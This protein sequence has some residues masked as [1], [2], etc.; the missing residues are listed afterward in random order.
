MRFDSIKKFLPRTVLLLTN[1]LLWSLG[2]T[3]ILQS[4][5]IRG[6]DVVAAFNIANTI[7]NVF[8]TIGTA[9]GIA[10]GI[11]IGNLLGANKIEEAKKASFVI[12]A[13]SVVVAL[14]FVGIMIL[15]SFFVPNVYKVSDAIKELSRDLIIVAA[16]SLPF[17]AFNC[18]CYFSLRAGGK[19]LLTMFFDCFYIWL[20]RLPVAFILCKYTSMGVVLAYALCWATEALK[21]IFGYYL[22]NKGVWLKTIV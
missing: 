2:L 15:C 5:S 22:V 9:L 17:Q 4:F 20:V 7:N 6:L 16:V 11:I 8:I 10:T 14:F 18:C 19:V 3:L 21:S 1:E 13:F 12:L